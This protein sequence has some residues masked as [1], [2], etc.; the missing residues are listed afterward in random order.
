VEV[1]PERGEGEAGARSRRSGQPRYWTAGGPGR[2]RE[3]GPAAARPGWGGPAP[4]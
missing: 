2:G 4:L 3:P 1:S